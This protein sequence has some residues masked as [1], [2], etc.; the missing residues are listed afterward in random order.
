MTDWNPLTVW[1]YSDC[2]LR[3]AADDYDATSLEIFFHL[4][5]NSIS[6]YYEV[7]KNGGWGWR[8]VQGGGSISKYYEVEKNG[9]WGWRGILRGGEE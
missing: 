3:F 1:F 6:K 2:Y 4:C 7:E 9:G 8:G 5:N